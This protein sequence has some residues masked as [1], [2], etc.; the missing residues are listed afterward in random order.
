MN[1]EP[2]ER[3]R[4]RR[5]FNS[6]GWGEILVII[7]AGLFI[8]GPERLPSAAASAGR[9]IRQAKD[10][11]AGAQEQL[12]EAVGPEYDDLRK[13]V[14]ELRRLRGRDPRR[15]MFDALLRDE[16]AP[17]RPAASDRQS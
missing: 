10:F 9:W 14:D 16:P 2:L 8:L 1:R 15:A 3:V 4:S 12:R 6:V 7:I 11:V 5:M 13:P 17:P